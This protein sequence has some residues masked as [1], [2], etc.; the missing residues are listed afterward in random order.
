MLPPDDWVAVFE[1]PRFDA[2]SERSLVLTSLAIPNEMLRQD[3]SYVVYVPGELAERSKFELWQ[4][5]QENRRDTGRRNIIPAPSLNAIPGVVAYVMLVCLVAWLA[6]EAAFGKD[7]LAAGRMDGQLFRNGEWWRSFT[8]LTLHSDIGHLAGNIVFGTLFGLLAGRVAGSGLAWLGIVLA[9]ALGNTINTLVLM[10]SHRSIG[11]S[12]AVFAALG[13]V[14]GFVWRGRFMAQDRWPYRVGPIVG[15]IA[16]L[17]Y[18]GTG[19]ENTDIGAHL[20]GFVCG[21]ATG[22]LLLRFVESFKDRRVQLVAGLA[23]LTA[24]A[25]SWIIALFTQVPAVSP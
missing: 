6:G 18:T 1:G 21:F 23:A 16:L 8:A 13:L 11:A 15:G 20:A 24:I 3:G 25:G 9:A 2:A 17:A 7:W 10:P 19:D 4:Y 5:G 12:T 14:S 22:M